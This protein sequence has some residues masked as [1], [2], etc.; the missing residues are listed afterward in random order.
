MW[1]VKKME[2]IYKSELNRIYELTEKALHSEIPNED[3]LIRINEIAQYY[4]LEKD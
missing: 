3:A 4:R 2:S 1:K